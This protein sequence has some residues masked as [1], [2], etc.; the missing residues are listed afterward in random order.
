MAFQAQW[1]ER[2]RLELRPE[3]AAPYDVLLGRAGV[4]ALEQQGRNWF[5]FP[6]ADPNEADAENYR[7]FAET[8]HTVCGE[9]LTAFRS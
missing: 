9:F 4:A 7:L 5:A 8:Q 6:K 3:N 2:A 1:F